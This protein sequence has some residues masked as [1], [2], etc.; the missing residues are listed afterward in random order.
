MSSM[1]IED[2]RIAPSLLRIFYLSLIVFLCFL[3]IFFSVY[4]PL[5]ISLILLILILSLIS[6]YTEQSSLFILSSI[7]IIFF[8]ERNL[9]LKLSPVKGISFMNIILGIGVFLFMI[10]NLK[11]KKKL[12][13]KS[14]LNWILLIL[15]LYSFASL[16]MNY[17]TGHYSVDIASLLALFKNHVINLFII[18]LIAFNLPDSKQDIKVFAYFLLGFFIFVIFIN[19]LTYYGIVKFISYEELGGYQKFKGAFQPGFRLMGIFQEPNIFASYII[20]FFPLSINMIYLTRKLSVKILL[21]VILFFSIFVLVLT[22]SRGGYF[23]FLVALGTLIY[24]NH[25][26]KIRTKK[27]LFFIVFIMI[28]M[29]ALV[30]LFFRDAFTVNVIGRLSFLKNF[31][32]DWSIKGRLNFW[33]L[34]SQQFLKSPIFGVG[35]HNYFGV[36][37]NF[38]YYLVTLGIIGFA[39]YLFLYYRIFQLS[40]NKLMSDRSSFSCFINLSF[41]AGFLGLLATMFF[42]EVYFVLYF[43]Y[44]YVGLVLKN[45][46]LEEQTSG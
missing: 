41:L 33:N 11:Q 23:G 46:L 34:G 39:V 18:F 2:T 13:L 12:F 7:C 8:F 45:N 29:L 43:F 17:S 9:G 32:I 1:F 28:V 35:W 42:L 20:L 27:H 19:I 10:K 31:E 25:K 5:K 4:I 6:L 36:C 22:G 38:L 3:V 14:P 24:L 26:I 40:F 44:L 15:V 21:L 30:S 16:A 37:N